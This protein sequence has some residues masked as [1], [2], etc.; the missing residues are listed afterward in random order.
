MI[1][2]SFRP[3]VGKL[4]LKKNLLRKTINTSKPQNQFPQNN[5]TVIKIAGA[6]PEICNEGRV[7]WWHAAGGTGV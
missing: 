4:V 1:G 6:Y 5:V 2:L 3:G 7:L